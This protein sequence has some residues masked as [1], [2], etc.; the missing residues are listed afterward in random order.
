MR[1]SVTALPDSAHRLGHRLVRPRNEG[2]VWGWNPALR[3][4][5]AAP[6]IRQRCTKACPSPHRLVSRGGKPA[7]ESGQNLAQLTILMRFS[8]DDRHEY[9]RTSAILRCI[10]AP[11]V[12]PAV[13]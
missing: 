10:G 4:A 6:S 7:E 3:R 9:F 11:P 8:M 1:A 5:P 13:G 2:P 12:S